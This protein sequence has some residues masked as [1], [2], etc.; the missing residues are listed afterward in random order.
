MIGISI[1]TKWE[2]DATLDY[3]KVRDNIVDYPYREYFVTEINNV[4][5]IFL[6]YRCKKS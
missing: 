1:A 4:D 2:R 3:F 5:T 6:Q